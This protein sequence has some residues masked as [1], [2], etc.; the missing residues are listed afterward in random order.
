MT[1][2]IYQNS[3]FQKMEHGNSESARVK[4]LDD[5]RPLNYYFRQPVRELGGVILKPQVRTKRLYGG[6]IQKYC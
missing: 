1:L 4:G 2:F 3:I 5:P 6:R